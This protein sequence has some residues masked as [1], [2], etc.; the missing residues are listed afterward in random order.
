M[1]LYASSKDVT[2]SDKTDREMMSRTRLIGAAAL[3]SYTTG[4]QTGLAT[5]ENRL[6]EM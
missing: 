2:T 4:N 6:W 5:E 3:Y 1:Y